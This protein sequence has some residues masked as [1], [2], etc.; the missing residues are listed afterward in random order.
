MIK[1]FAIAFIYLFMLQHLKAAEVKYLI[2]HVSQQ[3]KL[4]TNGKEEIAKR[5]LFVSNNNQS[6]ILASVSAI[7]ICPTPPQVKLLGNLW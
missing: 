5:G 6:L 1:M 4:K 3:V 7:A 2:Y